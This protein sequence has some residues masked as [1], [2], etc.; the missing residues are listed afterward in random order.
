MLEPAVVERARAVLKHAAYL[1]A[2]LHQFCVSVGVEEGFALLDWYADTANIDFIDVQALKDA[3]REARDLGDPF[4]VLK[5][6]R[7]LGLEVVRGQ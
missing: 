5:D 6:L 4:E 2:P 3:I 7:L 1:G